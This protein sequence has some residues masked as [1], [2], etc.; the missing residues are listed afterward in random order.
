MDK[1]DRRPA[2]FQN[3]AL[4]DCKNRTMNEKQTKLYYLGLRKMVSDLPNSSQEKRPEFTGSLMVYIPKSE[5]VSRFGAKWVQNDLYKEVDV[6]MSKAKI[7][8]KDDNGKWALFN[9]FSYVTYEGEKLTSEH[10]PTCRSGGFLI[11][12]EPPFVET[13]GLTLSPQA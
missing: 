4:I 5:L 9:I 1:Y 11:Q 12:R 7:K 8:I 3:N 2:V 10:T 6:M 13:E